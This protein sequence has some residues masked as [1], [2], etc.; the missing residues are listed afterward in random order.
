MGDIEFRK[1]TVEKPI[2]VGDKGFRAKAERYR[3]VLVSHRQ[4]NNPLG[5]KYIVGEGN[6]EYV[7]SLKDE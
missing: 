6:R 4:L 7:G 5:G 2:I 3:S 1:I